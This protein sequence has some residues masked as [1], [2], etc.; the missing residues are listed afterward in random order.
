M[1][2]KPSYRNSFEESLTKSLRIRGINTKKEISISDAVMM[3]QFMDKGINY[4]GLRKWIKKYGEKSIIHNLFNGNRY[5]F[6]GFVDSLKAIKADLEKTESDENQVYVTS[7]TG[8]MLHDPKKGDH[9]PAHATH[10]NQGLGSDAGWVGLHNMGYVAKLFADGF[11]Q[12]IDS[13][14][15][16]SLV[17][18]WYGLII[19]EAE[20]FAVAEDL[21]RDR[22]NFEGKML[23]GTIGDSKTVKDA[24]SIITNKGKADGM[25]YE[26]TNMLGVEVRKTCQKFD[27]VAG[28]II[29][30]AK[31]DGDS[32]ELNS[33]TARLFANILEGTAQN[34]GNVLAL[35]EKMIKIK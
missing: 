32:Q 17:Y 10:F 14:G 5:E 9:A 6:N 21:N 3:K 16:K 28:K 22:R 27:S 4:D 18:E 26:K 31:I 29:G 11:L 13:V 12:K 19:S 25:S 7:E 30:R 8:K 24:I 1:L 34:T 2:E 15:A 35:L 23:Q 20:A 33:K